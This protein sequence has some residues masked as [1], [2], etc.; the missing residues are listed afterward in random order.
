MIGFCYATADWI[1][2]YGQAC[3]IVGGLTLGLLFAIRYRYG[4]RNRKYLNNE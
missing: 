2:T 3:I 1:V 4:T